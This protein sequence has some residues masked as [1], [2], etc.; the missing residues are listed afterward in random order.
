LPC[1]ARQVE[2]V[3]HAPDIALKRQRDIARLLLGSTPGCLARVVE[4][5]HHDAE[6]DRDQRGAQADQCAFVR[7]AACRLAYWVVAD[8]V[9]RLP[10]GGKRRVLVN[11]NS[12]ESALIN[13]CH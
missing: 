5:P 12:F 2:R 10:A 3:D 4:R 11:G 7:A 1:R 13:V 9:L 8:G 6:H